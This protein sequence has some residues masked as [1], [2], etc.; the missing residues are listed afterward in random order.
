MSKH[1]SEFDIN[2][3][4]DRLFLRIFAIYNATNKP[5]A[6]GFCNSTQ[7]YNL[8]IGDEENQRHFKGDLWDLEFQLSMSFPWHYCVECG[9]NYYGGYCQCQANLL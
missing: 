1:N 9:R 4:L 6:L 8:T 5:F 2:K 3:P 7:V